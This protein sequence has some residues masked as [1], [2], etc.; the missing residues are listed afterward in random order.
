METNPIRKY[1]NIQS[2]LAS[3]LGEGLVSLG[4]VESH[5]SSHPIEKIVLGSGNS[6]R[7]LIS[8]GIH[9]DEPA[10]VE[11]ICSL[12]EGK[13]YL[14]FINSWEITLIPCINPFGYECGTRVNHEGVDLNRQFKS[15]SPSR[16]VALVK[17]VFHENPFD[18][19]MELHE[20]EDSSGYYLY[21]S[22]ASNLKTDLPISVLTEVQKVMPVNSDTKIDGLPARGGVIDRMSN[23]EN[24]DWWPMALYALSKG[25]HTCLTLETAL[26]FPMENRV[27]A[28]LKAIKTALDFFS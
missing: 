10:G 28:H 23:F 15:V 13:E 20:D 14:K 8:A 16:E 21:H 3:S 7:V 9:G 4:K 25:S 24:M 12:I 1:S 27:G 18:L 11:A 5:S 22:Y 2:R 19:T 6:K 26:Q 17:S